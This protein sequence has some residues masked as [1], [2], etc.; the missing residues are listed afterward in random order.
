[1]RVFE[2]K[3][4][5]LNHSFGWMKIFDYFSSRI[6]I[7]T[8]WYSWLFSLKR[9]NFNTSSS[10]Q[11]LVQQSRCS[12][13]HTTTIVIRSMRYILSEMKWNLDEFEMT[14]FQK[15]IRPFVNEFL[16]KISI[17]CDE[18]SQMAHGCEKNS[19]FWRIWGSALSRGIPRILI[20]LMNQ[21]Y[22]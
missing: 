21:S 4:L 10:N 18:C 11:C 12:H 6:G 15:F 8:T 17:W 2:G 22:L 14:T 20:E 9:F 3:S 5:R 1:M 7:S 19:F 13:S 16:P